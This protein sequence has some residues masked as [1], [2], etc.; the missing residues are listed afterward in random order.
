VGL[1]PNPKLL[2][3]LRSADLMLLVGARLSENPS[4]NYTL[5]GIPEPGR[6]LVHVHP[7]AEELNKIYH[8]SLAIQATPQA[9]CAAL[10]GVHPPRRIA[11]AGAG[12]AAHA[13]YLGWSDPGA[14]NPPGSVKMNL[15]MAEL[16]RVLPADTIVCNGAGNF[17]TWVHRFW[18]FRQY[19]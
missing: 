16:R 2:A 4:Q 14:V 12:S 10:E 18:R 5:L 7:S 6:T 3:R 13:D 19:G 8:A 9:F 15:V 1:G 17:A 11:W